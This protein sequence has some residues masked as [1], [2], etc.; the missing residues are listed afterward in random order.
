MAARQTEGFPAVH[1]SSEY[2]ERY[3]P[4]YR[5]IAIDL[6]LPAWYPERVRNL[7]EARG[8]S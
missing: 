1:H 8:Y 6:V 2:S 3:R 7:E 5:V 4:A